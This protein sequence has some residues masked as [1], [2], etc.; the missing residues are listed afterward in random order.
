MSF[1]K[2]KD[3]LVDGLASSGGST[4]LH[5]LLG[6]A[7]LGTLML[8]GCSASGQTITLNTSSIER[9]IARSLD[10][11]AGGLTIDVTPSV[12][13]PALMK[14]KIGDSWTCQARLSGLSIGVEVTI[15]NS[16]GGVDLRIKR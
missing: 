11:S 14:G 5:L 6:C 1:S 3:R 16:S 12:T 15:K 2:S 9:Q 8:A 4:R 10:F 7:L 13:C